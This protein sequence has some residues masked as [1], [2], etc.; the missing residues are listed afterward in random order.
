MG[1]HADKLTATRPDGGPRLAPRVRL[2]IE[3]VTAVIAGVVVLT[4]IG[5]C[6]AAQA[7]VL[8]QPKQSDLVAIRTIATLDRYDGSLATIAINGRRHT[9]VCAQHWGHAG[10]VLSVTVDHH[11]LIRKLGNTLDSHSKLALD[12]F[13]L[14]G[15]PRNVADW[16]TTQLNDG[17]PSSSGATYRYGHQVYEL[18]APEAPIGLAVFVLRS[19]GLPVGFAISGAGMRG[20]SQVRFTVRPSEFVDRLRAAF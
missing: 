18:R 4:T 11:G 5:L 6:F 9:A 3:V 17:N 16:L 10:R 15:C 2:G 14:A 7:L 1:S 13:E 8:G 19:A 20:T 12:E